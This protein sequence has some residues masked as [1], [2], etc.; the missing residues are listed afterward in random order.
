M[1]IGGDAPAGAQDVWGLWSLAGGVLVILL[2][3]VLLVVIIAS[4]VLKLVGRRKPWAKELS[5]RARWPFR[6]TLLLP[7][8][9]L[10]VAFT[11]IDVGW[12]Q[13]ILH[14][15]G[16]LAIGCSS[17]LLAQVC[18]FAI[19]TGTTRYHLLEDDSPAARRIRTQMQIVRRLI[20][21]V[22]VVIA[23][24]AILMT[25][26]QVRALGAS[27]LASAGVASVVAGLA[28][29]SLLGNLF[30]GV[31]L[32]FNEA[33]RVGDVVAVEGQ[34]GRVDEITLS[35]VVVTVW[36]G[37]TLVLPC[38]YF[39]SR[40]F[41]NWTRLGG[42]LLGTV[43]LDLVPYANIDEL[44][45]EL[46]RVLGATELWDGRRHAVD[47][48]DATGGLLQVRILVSAADSADLWALRC[49]VR[50][51]LIRWLREHAWLGVPGRHIIVDRP[52]VSDHVSTGTT[53]SAPPGE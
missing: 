45:H 47:V 1:R 48:T 25:F 17:W 8:L 5:R 7:T 34:T 44:R 27:L 42:E 20:V 38:T 49:L 14:L 31:Q 28:A 4:S 32:A 19:D 36:D 46:E 11:P 52:D 50:E 6:L 53:G 13:A 2:G 15:L 24:G 10:A 21:A 3:I 37:R 33:I 39:T 18:L 26:D 51:E 12:K 43:Y 35:Y 30:A 16:I 9:M 29:Q 40:P 41:E 23:V 22:I